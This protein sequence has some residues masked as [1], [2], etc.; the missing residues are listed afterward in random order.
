MAKKEKEINNNPRLLIVRDC[1]IYLRNAC[2]AA[3]DI[4]NLLPHINLVYYVPQIAKERMSFYISSKHLPVQT[5][6]QKH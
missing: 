4:F 1:Q 6:Q 2:N 5:Q 3:R